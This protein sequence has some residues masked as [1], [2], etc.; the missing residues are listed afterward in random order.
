LF[1]RRYTGPIYAGDDK[2]FAAALDDDVTTLSLTSYG[3]S[4]NAA[5]NIGRLVRA[6]KLNTEAPV[7]CVSSCA[8]IWAAGSKRTATGRLVMHCPIA[9]EF[10]C[11]PAVRA[12]MITYLKEM[13]AMMTTRSCTPST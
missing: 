4:V 6:R 1:P 9:G 13:H 2:T 3:G 12:D 7:F 5:M 11:L 8:L 10:R